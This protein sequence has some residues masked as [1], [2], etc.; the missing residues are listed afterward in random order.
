M[1]TYDQ[2]YPG[3]GFCSHK[4]YGTLAHMAAISTA[5]SSPIHR[6]SFAPLKYQA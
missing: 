1:R 5:G 3:Y 4:G 2:Q 6:H